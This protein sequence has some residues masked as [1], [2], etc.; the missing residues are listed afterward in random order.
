MKFNYKEYGIDTIRP[1]IPIQLI[2]NNQK[3]GYEVLVDSGADLCVFNAE[4]GEAIGID[5]ERGK[6]RMISGIGGKSAIMFL[7]TVQIKVGEQEYKIEAGF[8][9]D[10]AG[11]VIQYGVVGQQG[12]FENFIVKFDYQ[13]EEIELK[14]YS[15]K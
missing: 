13:K 12:F 15:S 6:R 14:N 8:M 1:I 11:R 10:V 2:H 3:I 9:P 4:I 7:H 5:I